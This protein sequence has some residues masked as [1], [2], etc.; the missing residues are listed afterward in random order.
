MTGSAEI[1]LAG[2]LVTDPELHVTSTGAVATFTVA[3]DERRF[4]PA[5]KQWMDTGTTF[6]PC[7][8]GRQAAESVTESVTKGTRVLVTGVL[9]Q[10]EWET[11]EGD[12]R[13]AYEVHATEVA[14]SLNY[15]TVQ[16]TRTNT[17]LDNDHEHK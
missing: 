10:R 13:Y 12:K 14:V 5:T 2:I 9:R 8:V 6:L 11:T 17:T 4:D 16:I 7:S 1:T 3:A 15:A